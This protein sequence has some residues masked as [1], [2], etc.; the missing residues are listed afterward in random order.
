[1]YEN[2]H[3]KYLFTSER[4]G[5]RNW[6]SKDL[7]NFAA[8]NANP[9]VMEFFPKVLSVQESADMMGRMQ[10]HFDQRGF[11]YFATEVIETGELIGFVGLAYQ[12]YASEFNPA[13]DIGW[14][15]KHSAWG[16]GFATEGAKRCLTY[17]FESLGLDRIVAIFSEKNIRSE[18]VM[19]KIGMLKRGRFLHPKLNE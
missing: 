13:V 1:M 10:N 8:L 5:F 19:N 16:Q 9:R 17:G 18:H 2:A 4:L 7:E 14:R 6:E 12:D 11:C 15:L 3:K